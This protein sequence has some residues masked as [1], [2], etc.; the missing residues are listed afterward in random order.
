MRR[1]YP[2]NPTPQS[3]F[4]P[5]PSPPKRPGAYVGPILLV[6]ITTAGL[7]AVLFALLVVLKVVTAAAATMA[8]AGPAV[9]GVA[10]SLALRKRD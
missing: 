4:P 2:V 8:T 5:Q 9:G 3:Q 6:A 7:C 1:R 10:L